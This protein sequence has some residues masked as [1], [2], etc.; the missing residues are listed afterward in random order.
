[1]KHLENADGEICAENGSAN[2]TLGGFCAMILILALFGANSKAHI[3]VTILRS[4][5]NESHDIINTIES[6]AGRSV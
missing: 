4:K 2:S 1:M 3:L 5:D 6:H